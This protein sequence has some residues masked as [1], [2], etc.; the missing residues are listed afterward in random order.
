M[1]T[2]WLGASGN[3]GSFWSSTQYSAYPVS[4]WQQYF[5]GGATDQQYPT[6]KSSQVGV[7]CARVLTN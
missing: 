3:L 4:A 2:N 6:S 1:D 5:N 7:R